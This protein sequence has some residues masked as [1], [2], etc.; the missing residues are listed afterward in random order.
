MKSRIM[1]HTRTKDKSKLKYSL[2]MDF[3]SEKILPNNIIS[4]VL[5]IAWAKPKDADIGSKKTGN[6]IINTRLDRMISKNKTYG[7]LP[8]IIKK[9]LNYFIERAKKYY[10]TMD[11]SNT[12]IML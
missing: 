4:P 8:R 10:K 9:D 6:A 12:V 7:E 11:I 3:I 1:F 5:Y 2:G